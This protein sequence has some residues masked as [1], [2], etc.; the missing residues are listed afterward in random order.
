MNKKG[1]MWKHPNRGVLGAGE[2]KGRELSREKSG[3]GD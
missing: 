1:C 2:A 3:E